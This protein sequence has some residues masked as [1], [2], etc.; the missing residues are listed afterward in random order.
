MKKQFVNQLKVGDKVNDYFVI[1]KISQIPYVKNPS[2]GKF[3]AIELRDKTGTID[4]KKWTKGAETTALHDS[5]K[6]VQIIK[7]SGDVDEFRNM[8]SITLDKNP[9]IVSDYEFPEDFI[10]TTKKDIQQMIEEL[11]NEISKIS[12]THIKQLL[13]SFSED[14]EFMKIF[15]RAAAAKKMHHNFVGGLLEHVLNLIAISKTVQARHPELDSDLLVAACILHDIGK[16]EELDMGV[17]I[18]FSD[19]GRFYS[20]ISI[21]FRMVSKM[22][23][24]ISDFPKELERKIL[25]II[26]SHHGKQEYGSPVKPMF[27]EAI[28]FHHIDNSDATIQ[29][30]KQIIQDNNDEEWVWGP[31]RDLYYTK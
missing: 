13:E 10:L 4:A 29:K 20:H 11:K 26:L 14:D 31:D 25:H 9:E 18:D 7:I 12:N 5:L 30:V 2:D 6:G 22:I 28:A 27:L 21:G 19:D 8:P 1:E 3:L 15:S 16:V 24:K 23:E 17:K